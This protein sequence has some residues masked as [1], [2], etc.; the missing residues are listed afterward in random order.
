VL[1]RFVQ[2]SLNNC[3]L[4]HDHGQQLCNLSQSRIHTPNEWLSDLLQ[5]RG[6]RLTIRGQRMLCLVIDAARWVYACI[7]AARAPFPIAASQPTPLRLLDHGRE[8]VFVSL[9]ASHTY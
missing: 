9:V 2:A 8:P 7:S 1:H 6:T 3:K 4:A 5:Y